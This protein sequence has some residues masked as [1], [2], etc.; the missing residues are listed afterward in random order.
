M[1]ILNW[2][3][4]GIV[5]HTTFNNGAILTGEDIKIF[6]NPG[7]LLAIGKSRKFI[8]RSVP[9]FKGQTKN[10][11]IGVLFKANLG[12]SYV[13]E[14]SYETQKEWG[15]GAQVW[16]TGQAWG[17]QFALWKDGDQ[18]RV[19]TPDEIQDLRREFVRKGILF[20]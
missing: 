3:S 1:G 18:M 14:I 16:R 6:S 5:V 13:G 10:G 20:E 19:M 11:L 7:N 9:E 2:L 17:Y 12:P 4:H 8:G 15:F